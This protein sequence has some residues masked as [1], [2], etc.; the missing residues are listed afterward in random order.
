[1]VAA[2]G[3]ES[4]GWFIGEY[5]GTKLWLLDNEVGGYT[6]MLPEDN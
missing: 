5:D 4:E 1:M 2:C 3:R 6:L